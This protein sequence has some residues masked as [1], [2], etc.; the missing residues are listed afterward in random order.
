MK[1][2]PKRATRIE[3]IDFL[4]SL[5]RLI[6]VDPKEIESEIAKTKNQEE[7]A[8]LYVEERQAS[9]RRGA[10]RAPKRFRP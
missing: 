9:I 3:G 5:K 8:K 7:E 4:E 1:D 10:R 2:K 6:G